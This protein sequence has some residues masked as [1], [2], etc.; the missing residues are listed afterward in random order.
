[1]GIPD[2]ILMKFD[3]RL[4]FDE[5]KYLVVMSF[6]FILHT[7][8]ERNTQCCQTSLQH[9]HQYLSFVFAK[10]LSWQKISRPNAG[11]TDVIDGNASVH[12]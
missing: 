11:A 5:V 3:V 9:Y 12:S 1:M 6:I 7:M 4:I 8:N 10:A 2:M